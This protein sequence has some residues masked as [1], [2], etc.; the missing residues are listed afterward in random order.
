[1]RRR[2]DLRRLEPTTNGMEKNK[3]ARLARRTNVAG[4]MDDDTTFA[5]QLRV[6]LVRFTLFILLFSC[7]F[8]RVLHS[9]RSRAY[10]AGT[11]MSA[12]QVV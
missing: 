2:Y 8:V 10:T 11:A 1:V 5:W 3:E 6:V 7:R 4:V 12:G 9:W